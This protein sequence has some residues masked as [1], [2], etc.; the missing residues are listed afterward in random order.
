VIIVFNSQNH[1][2]KVA[3]WQVINDKETRLLWHNE[4]SVLTFYDFPV[5]MDYELNLFSQHSTGIVLKPTP[6]PWDTA[7]LPV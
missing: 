6:L 2:Q 5:S 3:H 4:Y 7:Y 1:W